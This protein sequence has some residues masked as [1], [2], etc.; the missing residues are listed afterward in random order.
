MRF[1]PRAREARGAGVRSL[2]NGLEVLWG[3]PGGLLRL[4]F[5][6]WVYDGES[7]QLFKGETP[8]HL[9]PKAFD[10]LGALLE[11]RPRAL[12]KAEIR[13]RLWP[14]TFV[15][16]ATLASVVSELRSSLADD[17]KE[18][19]FV[20]TVHGHGYAFSGSAVEERLGAAPRDARRRWAGVLGA[21]TLLGVGAFFLKSD[22]GTSRTA[23]APRALA[24]LP[25]E[26][27]STEPGQAYI[28]DGLT[29][30]LMTRL[31]ESGIRVVSRTS[32]L[33]HRGSNRPR[34]EIGKELGADWLVEGSA[35]H[36]GPQV[37]LTVRLV[38]ALADRSLWTRTYEC[39]FDESAQLPARI[40]RD[41]VD[42]SRLVLTP[43]QEAR[44]S[45]ARP[46]DPEAYDMFL[47]GRYQL[48]RGS[49]ESNRQAIELLQQSLGK[50]PRY[51]P[52]YAGLSNAYI[53][54]ASVWA[55]EPPRP[56]RALAAAAAR[57]A[58]ELDP[59]LADAHTYLGS[60]KL[61][62]WDFAGAEREFL[63]AIE[64]DPSAANAHLGHASYLVARGRMNE[65]LTEA[66][67]AETLDPLSVR[68]RRY[69]GYVLF[70]ARRYDE[71][72]ASLQAVVATEP[73][74]TFTR[75]FLGMAY[76]WAGRHG[77]A[78]AELE[79]AVTVSDHT[80][81]IVGA[82]AAVQARAGNEGEARRLLAGLE[83]SSR[84]RYVSPA[85]FILAHCELG[86]REQAF[87]WLERGF[88]ERI[89]FMIFVNNMETLDPLRGDPRFRELVKRIGL[90]Q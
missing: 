46:V 53:T 85:S 38:D 58:V 75:W 25:L 17:P 41:I 87:R 73:K 1:L 31:A 56:M 61:Y 15:T 10:L 18:P 45:S 69:V 48:A 44:L 21:L 88:E 12:S 80:P 13:D 6:D 40:A 16:E 82:L 50:D 4:R 32:V 28:A 76:S 78:V 70:Q 60:L 81:S 9:P 7:R 62:D 55:G 24:V 5:E 77:E 51:A 27:V 49:L 26:D 89:N 63:R 34:S 67:R 54:L 65:A 84:R 90:P 39:A 11:A 33:R 43:Q 74:D 52:A 79:Q 57:K 68:A 20:R 83:E 59:D 8:V 22:T 71:A 42:A 72:I 19:R 36:V 47:K 35:R 3:F 23:S 66:R 29:E 2:G 86:E 30:A 64:L 14:E 37:H